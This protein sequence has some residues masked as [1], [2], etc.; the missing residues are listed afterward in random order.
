MT[1]QKAKQAARTS[2]KLLTAQEQALCKIIARREAPYNQRAS[3]LLFMNGNN[4][5]A[6][7]AEAAGM[8][9]GQVKYWMARF[10][11]ERMAIFPEELK[12]TSKAKK[13]KTAAPEK[14]T[15]PKALKAKEEA[16]VPEPKSGKKEKKGKKKTRKG[17]KGKKAKKGKKGK[18]AGKG[19]KK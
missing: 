15:P 8:S 9:T 19:K 1:I 13:A 3:M 17:K 18:K 14:A 6:Q 12:G 4:T 16:A 11:K 2:D 7:A 10:R 5:Q